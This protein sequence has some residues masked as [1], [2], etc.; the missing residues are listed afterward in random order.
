VER[1]KQY[2]GAAILAVVVGVV[3]V[4][5]VL[6]QTD[7]DQ[8]WQVQFS[9][10]AE[11][12]PDAAAAI[13]A[14]AA[15]AVERADAVVLI[16]GHTGTRGD[17]EANAALS[18]ERA[19]A[20]RAALVAARVPADR[21]VTV[22]AG[23]EQPLTREAEETDRAYQLRLGRAEILVTDEP[24]ASETGQGPTDGQAPADDSG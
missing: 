20:V 12:A 7:S 13:E 21:I 24:P 23:A 4:Q 1:L 17:P 16:T 15:E 14:A 6:E 10:G 2:I 11:L 22:A 3:A 18:L 8:R 9:R 5:S 19:E